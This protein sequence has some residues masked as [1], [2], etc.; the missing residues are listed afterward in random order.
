MSVNQLK[1][2]VSKGRGLASANQFLVELPSLGVYDTR[3]L[4]VLCT[5]VNMPGRQIMTQERLIGMKAYHLSRLL[6]C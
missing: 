3:E 5:N 1:A 6:E 4:N 2:A